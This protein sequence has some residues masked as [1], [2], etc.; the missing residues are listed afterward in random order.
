ME[1][2][3]I[4]TYLVRKSYQQYRRLEFFSVC[5]R[6]NIFSEDTLRKP[7]DHDNKIPNNFLLHHIIPKER[8]DWCRSWLLYG[9]CAASSFGHLCR[10]EFVVVTST[11]RGINPSTK[12]ANCSSICC[13]P[14]QDH[15]IL[16]VSLSEFVG[17]IRS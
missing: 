17:S 10:W 5:D 2:I 16:Q 9:T 14:R 15:Q 1:I 7:P 3:S 6:N 11:R 8:G 12:G 13:P 4:C